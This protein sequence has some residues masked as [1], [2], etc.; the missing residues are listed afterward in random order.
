MLGLYKTCKK[1]RA[2]FY[3]FIGDRL[4]IKGPKIPPLPTLAR[5]TPS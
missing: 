4:G 5:A 1:L 2:S 3:H